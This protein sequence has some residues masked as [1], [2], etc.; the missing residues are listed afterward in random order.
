VDDH[1]FQGRYQSVK[2]FVR[3]LRGRPGTEACAVIVT[4]PGEEAQ[5]D[6]GCGPMVRDPQSGRYHRTRLFVLTLGYSRKAVRLLSFDSSVRIWA[7]FH[8][9]AFRRLGGATRTI[10]LDNLREGVLKPDIYDPSLN[11]L[12]RDLL[13]HYGA[14]ALPCRVADPDRKGNVNKQMEALTGCTRDE[15]IG[16]PFKHYFTDSDRAEAGIERVLLESKV[17]DYELTACAHDGRETVVSHN[18]TTFYDRDRNLRGVFAAARDVTERKRFERALQENN[19]ELERAKAAAEKANLAKSEFL[20]SMS[21]EI[22]TPMNAILGM[23]DSLRESKLDADQLQYE[24]L[25]QR[26]GAALLALINE[27]L[28]LSKIE[29]GHLDMES[30][31]F[32][33]AEVTSQAIELTAVKAHAKGIR[34]VSRLAPGLTTALIGDPSRLRRILINLLGNAVKF[35]EEG[36]VALTLTKHGDGNSGEI[37]FAVSDTGIGIPTDK[38]ETIF[39]NFTQLDTSATRKNEGTGLGL[40]ISRRIVEALAGTLTATSVT[41]IGSTFAFTARFDP[42]PEAGRKAPDLRAAR[43]YRDRN[44]PVTPA[45]LLVAEDSQD[46]RLLIQAYLKNSPYL[47]TFEENGRDAGGAI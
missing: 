33:L 23:A 11:P 38:L 42:A 17:T 16:T 27:I 20:S 35:T 8:E 37:E 5:V 9:L 22:R 31:T 29:A 43:P 15:L 36:E 45:R 18:A 21:H 41:G 39:D 44:E 26:A 7:E 25:F 12:Y 2:R 14:V 28:D 3:Q 30:V 4:P 34:L 6:Y 19:F 24:E 13:A 47:L 46:N 40:A 32:D 1:G 10:V